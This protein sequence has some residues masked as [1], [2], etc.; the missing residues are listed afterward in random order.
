MGGDHYVIS[1]LGTPRAG[2]TLLC[3]ECAEPAEFN[4]VALLQRTHYLIQDNA[5]NSIKVTLVKV[6]VL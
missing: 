3:R 2:D 4:A 5:D 6:R 1:L